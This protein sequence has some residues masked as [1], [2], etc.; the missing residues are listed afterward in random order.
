MSP[1]LVMI[2]SLCKSYGIKYVLLRKPQ[3]F[4]G[5]FDETNKQ[6]VLA[7]YRL[8]TITGQV[9][10]NPDWRLQITGLHELT[11]MIQSKR[12]DAAW[13][14]TLDEMPIADYILRY[15]AGEE[16]C[17]K[18]TAIESAKIVMKLEWEA[19]KRAVEMS[20]LFKL[21]YPRSD[22]IREAKAYCYS[23][24]F[25]AVTGIV[26]SSHIRDKWKMILNGDLTYDLNRE[27]LRKLTKIARENK[28]LWLGYWKGKTYYKNAGVG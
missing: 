18:E 3:T 25:T 2:K 6:L 17:P 26:V 10:K 28:H 4:L 7:Q 11:H 19:E 12:G 1:I 24:Y 22:Y 8:D 13:N 20:D 21:D 5:I 16:W 23:Y 15:E 14:A 9:S 27:M